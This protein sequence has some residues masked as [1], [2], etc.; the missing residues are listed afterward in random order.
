MTISQ[1]PERPS[2]VAVYCALVLVAGQLGACEMAGQ[3]PEQYKSSVEGVSRSQGR[4]SLYPKGGKRDSEAI[5]NSHSLPV[6]RAA[7]IAA[8]LPT[9]VDLSAQLPPPGNQGGEGSCAGFAAA[10]AKDYDEQVEMRW[11][12]LSTDHQFSPSWLY[13]QNNGGGDNGAF[14]SDVL[15]TIVNHGADTLS[16][17]LYRD[18]DVWTQPDNVSL[19]RASHYKALSWNSLTVSASSLK[20]YLAGGNVVIFGFN[21]FPDLDALNATT[22]VIYDSSAGTATQYHFVA[23]VG[24]DDTKAAFKFINSW[25]S[26]WGSSGY[27]WI[28]YSFI[29]DSTLGLT[30][31]LLNDKANVPGIVEHSTIWFASSRILN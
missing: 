5:L 29:T 15:N 12:L 26:A 20:S 18:G 11:S 7:A 8:A 27:G 21:A 30:A 9:S 4:P 24:Y 10:Y 22:N 14:M 16:N 28:A 17:F 6:G 1:F 25:G 23:V 3:E 2:K 19:E 13:N 31:Y